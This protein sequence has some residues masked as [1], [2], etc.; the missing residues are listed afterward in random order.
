[1]RARWLSLALF[2]AGCEPVGAIPDGA[3]ADA[4]AADRARDEATLDGAPDAL[5]FD[6]ARDAAITEDASAD[7]AREASVSREYEWDLDGNGNAESNVRVQPCSG[8]ASTCAVIDSALWDGAHEIELSPA[9]QR[10]AGSLIGPR[11]ALIGTHAGDALSEVAI[12]HCVERGANTPPALSVIDPRA[13]V[14]IAQ[15]IAPDTQRNAWVDAIRGPDDKRYPFLAPSYGDGDTT[16]TYG[17]AIW[18]RVCIYRGGAAATSACGADW[19]A[20]DTTVASVTNWFREVGGTLFDLDG[21]RWQDLTLSY[22]WAAHSISG[23][24]GA[25]LATT[26]YDVAPSMAP[27]GFHSGR[28][29]GTH[30]VSR[31]ADGT[32]R[33]TIVAGAPVGTFDDYNCN[34]SRFIAVL[35]AREGSPTSRRLAWSRYMGFASTI[36]DAPFTSEYAAHPE[37][38]IARPA[39]AMHQCVHR[40]SDSRATIDGT[41]SVVVNY[42][43]QDAPV[44]LCLSLQFDLYVA[45][46][47]TDAKSAAWYSC[48]AR[49]VRSRGV[50]GMMALRESDGASVTGGLEVY[51]WGRAS[52][53]TPSGETLYLVESLPGAGAFDLSD[54]SPSALTVYGI[55]RGLFQNRGALPRAGRPRILRSAAT[56]SVGLGSYSFVAELE[57][58]DRDGDGYADVHMNDGSWVGWD[59]AANRWTIK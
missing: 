41:P 43:R 31:G 57:L 36:F 45:P 13:A 34:V 5:V 55:E 6:G 2:A 8:R 12:A 17:S 22:H 40:F 59:R 19:I 50:W 24:T 7:A 33:T 29:Y 23:R 46:A 28:N 39:D 18:G 48:F 1:M 44:D 27:T 15:V 53:L 20:G 56:P 32:I 49:N 38:R 58:E 21:D 30:A 42:F 51:V 47:W 35:D 3:G 16:G 4:I 25:V 9:G 26:V 11:V 14:R 52:N 37:A 10:C 54:R